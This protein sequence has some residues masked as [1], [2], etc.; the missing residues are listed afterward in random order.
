LDFSAG[1]FRER[2]RLDEDEDGGRDVVFAGEGDAHGGGD[3]GGVEVAEGGALDLKDEGDGFGA[4]GSGDREG[5][6]AVGAESGARIDG[7]GFEVLRVVV[8]AADDDE[9]FEASGDEE[10]AG[11]QEAEVAGAEVTEAR[12]RGVGEAGAEGGGGERGVLPV[13]GADAGAA[14]PNFAESRRRVGEDW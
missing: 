13:A 7:G 14:D 2:R 12:A 4:V 6:A 3:G 10:F 1:G 5:G 11:A 9:V 8:A